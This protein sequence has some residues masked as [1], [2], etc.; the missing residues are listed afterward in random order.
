MVDRTEEMVI[1][2][3]VDNARMEEKILNL[4]GYVLKDLK[5]SLDDISK[6][7]EATFKW[8]IGILIAFMGISIAVP[9]AICG[10]G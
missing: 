1:D 4:E 5:T 2:L 3:R 9:L 7:M 6:K 10:G 8:M